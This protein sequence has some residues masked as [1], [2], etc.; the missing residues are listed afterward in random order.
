MVVKTKSDSVALRSELENANRVIAEKEI[1]TS[2]LVAQVDSLELALSEMK[3]GSETVTKKNDVDVDVLKSQLADAEQKLS[4]RNTI[5]S[6]LVA[7]VQNLQKLLEAK[8]KLI[9]AQAAQ[10]ENVHRQLEVAK[11]R[12][13]GRLQT[14]NTENGTNGTT[15]ISPSGKSDAEIKAVESQTKSIQRETSND[16]KESVLPELMNFL[17]HSS[18]SLSIHEPKLP[19]SEVI[20]AVST[21]K[22]APPQSDEYTVPLSGDEEE[23][24][25]QMALQVKKK[26]RK[27][28]KNGRER[29]SRKQKQHGK[30]KKRASR[31][32]KRKENLDP[33]YLRKLFKDSVNKLIEVNRSMN[34]KFEREISADRKSFDRSSSVLDNWV[35][36]AEW[37]DFF[38]DEEGDSDED[39]DKTL[40]SI[41]L[42]NKSL[43]E[44]VGNT[45]SQI[46]PGSK[47]TK[48]ILKR[49]TAAST[50]SVKSNTARFFRWLGEDPVFREFSIDKIPSDLKNDL[51]YTSEDYRIFAFEK[52]MD[53]NQD[54]F[55]LVESDDE[56]NSYYEEESYYS[57]SSSSYTEEELTASYVDEE[58]SDSEY[59]IESDKEIEVKP[60]RRRSIL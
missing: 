39:I 22:P 44:S 8:E 12:V 10:I 14:R 15:V 33:E 27:P 18:G 57:G 38:S 51:W 2:S 17:H 37:N 26:K 1:V 25:K 30:R 45:P 34:K 35:A 41:A 50:V 9:S 28:R 4:E 48:G 6:S 43:E 24:T 29:R 16:S 23:N 32:K 20:V 40:P 49:Q 52:Y 60:N 3:N 36:P 54:E 58:L 31:R 11:D 7:Q 19:I 59:T 42:S 53:E 13:V 47:S 5:V 55:E 46:N 56:E 21:G